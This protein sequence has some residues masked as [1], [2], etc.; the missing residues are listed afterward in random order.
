MALCSPHGSHPYWL[1]ADAASTRVGAGEAAA[2]RLLAELPL[3]RRD[4][5]DRLELSETAA[6]AILSRLRG[7]GLV[8]PNGHRRGAAWALPTPE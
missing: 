1:R 7:H 4:L 3:A 8:H 6:T 5:S 2:L